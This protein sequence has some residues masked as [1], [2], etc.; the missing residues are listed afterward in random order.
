MLSLPRSGRSMSASPL[1]HK[2]VDQEIYDI[3]RLEMTDDGFKVGLTFGPYQTSEN[4]N[5]E[6]IILKTEVNFAS[7]ARVDFYSDEGYDQSFKDSDLFEI[8]DSNVP[9][10]IVSGKS[11]YLD[12]YKRKE[13]WAA[14]CHKEDFRHFVVWSYGSGVIHIL[15]DIDPIIGK[16]ANAH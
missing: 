14:I 3:T 12:E 13:E 11:V 5:E 10:L 6:K 8:V 2:N 16:I 4:A 1:H 9:G 7:P 15:S